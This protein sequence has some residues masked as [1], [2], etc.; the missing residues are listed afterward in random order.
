M[1]N[2]LIFKIE[3]QF[4]AENHLHSVEDNVEE[5]FRKSQNF[6]VDNCL[7][8]K[9]SLPEVLSK[10]G[11]TISDKVTNNEESS[12]KI[13]EN[14]NQISQVNQSSFL[15]EIVDYKSEWNQL[16]DSEK[17]LGLQAPVWLPDSETNNCLKCG[18]KFTFRKRRHHCRA[19]G[20]IFCSSCCNEKLELPYK[21]NN[22]EPAKE[23]TKVELSRVCLVC[24]K[25]ITKVTELKEK[26]NQMENSVPIV[27]VLKKAKSNEI[28]DADLTGKLI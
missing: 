23:L 2:D 8:Y 9:L 6:E 28:T 7:E 10:N 16:T 13:N 25:T 19:C 5:N 12:T 18:L 26:I 22:N 17:M 11:Q 14:L 21:L 20:L 3:C 24:F 15:V 4:E 27:S 1:L